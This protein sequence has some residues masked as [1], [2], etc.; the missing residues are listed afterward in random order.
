MAWCR[1][2]IGFQWTLISIQFIV[3]QLIPDEPEEAIIQLERQR[4]IVTKVL[5][6]LEDE[7]TIKVADYAEWSSKPHVEADDS[8]QLPDFPV[9]RYPRA[10]GGLVNN[11]MSY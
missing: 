10:G 4:F 9:Q 7:E 5:D 6:H 1:I 3:E 8:A 2:F 11:P